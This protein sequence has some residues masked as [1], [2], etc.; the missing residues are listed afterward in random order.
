MSIAI[1]AFFAF[2]FEPFATGDTAKIFFGIQGMAVVA[3]NKIGS[4]CLSPR[5]P[6]SLVG[7]RSD[8]KI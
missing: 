8:E 1:S 3:W 4:A 7:D 5:Y 6:I 2:Y